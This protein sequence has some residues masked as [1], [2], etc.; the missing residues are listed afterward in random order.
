MGQRLAL[1]RLVGAVVIIVGEVGVKLLVELATIG[2]GIEVDALPLD[3]APEAL[4]RGPAA[5]VAAD[6]AAGSQQRLPKRLAGEL[7][8]LIGVEDKRGR[9]LPQDR[10][11]G[12]QAET[13]IERIR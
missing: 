1:E 2:G 11:Q 5:P 9:L 6:L 3:R 12:A 7:A 13:H 8:V 4:F 10:V